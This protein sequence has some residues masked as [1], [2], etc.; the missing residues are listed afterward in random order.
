[1]PVKPIPDGYRTVTPTLIV[2]GAD[3]LIRFATEAFGANER[4]RMPMPDGK[5]AHAELELG[6]SV[7]M[8]ADAME[9]FPAHPGYI[10]LYVEDADA[11]YRRALQAGATTVQEPQNQF[12]G[13]RSGAVAD[14]FGNRWSIS[15]HVE[16]VPEDEMMRRMAEMATTQ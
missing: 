14:S 7:I 6:D 10:H 8:V 1:M 13:D 12:Y 2:D 9:G 3:Q 5:V 15:T 16:D 11:V 4:L